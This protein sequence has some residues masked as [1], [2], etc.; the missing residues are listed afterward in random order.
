MK[1]KRLMNITALFLALVFCFTILSRAS[2][3]YAAVVVRVSKPESRTISHQ[4]IST[5][6][7]VQNQELA[8]VTEPNQRVTAI[9]VKEGQQV[10]KGDLL[11]EIDQ[12]LLEEKI[13]GQQQEM[14]K[15]KLQVQDAK[16]QKEVSARQKANEQAQAAEN[17]S[18]NTQ[19]ASVRL[20]RAKRDL[21]DAK[22]QL[23]DFRKSNGS[24]VQDSG[25]EE[26]L[27]AAYQEKQEAYI[28]AQQELTELQ[29]Q[30]ENAV[31]EAKNEALQGA[32]AG[33]SDRD[34][35][36]TEPQAGLIIND[37]VRTGSGEELLLEDSGE[38]TL[39]E[40]TPIPQTENVVQEAIPEADAQEITPEMVEPEAVS[41]NDVQEET[42]GKTD[43]LGQTTDTDDLIIED[44]VTDW[45]E[46]SSADNQTSETVPN[47][48]IPEDD[49]I[50]ED[51]VIDGAENE[52]METDLQE[53]G[54]GETERNL[55][56]AEL[57]QIEASVRSQWQSQLIAAQDKVNHALEEKNNAQAALEQYQQ[58]RLSASDTQNTQ[59]EQQLL[60]AVQAARD[61]Y[62][63][64]SLAANEA[65]VVSGRAV[66]SAGIPNASN[67]SD[68]VN[69]ITYE[70]M[71]LELEKLET[72]KA[73]DGKIYAP[74]DGLVTKINIVTGEKTSDTTAVLMADISKG[75]RFTT[76]ITKEQEKY[77][78][79]GDLVTLISG[80]KK[81]K[82]EELEISSV[83][84]DEE[85]EDIYQVIV[86][87]PEDSFEIGMS[88]TMEFVKKSATYS[89]C[90]PLSALHL[91]EKNQTYVL[92]A[93]EYQSV[94]GTELRA[95]K[96][97]V[98]VQEKN[99]SYVA[100]A[101][102]VLTSQQQV[103]TYSNKTVEEGSR[104][105]I[106]E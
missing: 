40:Q 15:Q 55:S 13:L 42:A 66:A 26:A 64:A 16:S 100:L 97:A 22:H 74:A 57:D 95:R 94:M 63:D 38:Q 61:A 80:N 4:V 85:K 17:Y 9:Y 44:M 83:R 19:S 25:V 32:T 89:C 21:A 49:F 24:E 103:I 14:E 48:Q 5:G 98:T 101:E 77:I 18:L 27:E 106:E 8:V 34:N 81:I 105:R 73:E 12:K 70:Q 10:T 88:V 47:Q 93:D 104:I 69:E 1:R 20:S 52:S 56:Q 72:L 62:E 3:Q 79:T 65:A 67:S 36:G 45:Q 102:G 71:E 86:E 28:Q 78:G 2:Y 31:N 51:F 75:Y 59:T 91:D 6:K 30:I 84:A 35:M 53:N 43:T 46:T 33:Q 76:E 37:T 41:K 99:E 60:V 82:L 54:F 90:V 7:V 39:T 58:E 23:E 50:I 87:L 11:F 92:V 29:W 68:R 96:V